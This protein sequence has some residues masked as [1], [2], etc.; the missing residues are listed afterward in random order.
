MVLSIAALVLFTPRA[1][2]PQSLPISPTASFDFTG[3]PLLRSTKAYPH[4]VRVVSHSVTLEIHGETVRIESTTV[5]R[6]GR[7]EEMP[8]EVLIPRYRAGDAASG[9]PDFGVSV[10][11]DKRPL[12][13]Q[14]AS[15]RAAT[16]QVRPGLEQIRYRST[17]VGKTAMKAEGTHAVR[18]VATVPLGRSG[19]ERKQRIVGYSLENTAT[20]IETFDITIRDA[21]GKMFN[22]P[23]LRPRWRWQSSMKG[24]YLRQTFFRPEGQIVTATFYPDGFEDIGGTTAGG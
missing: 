11:W 3:I 17:L 14:P 18:V 8:T 4:R 19:F 23:E 20:Q 24:A 7:K 2:E 12:E 10:T 1:V 16:E 22:L 5:F 6:N 9:G 15:D 21:S 13:L